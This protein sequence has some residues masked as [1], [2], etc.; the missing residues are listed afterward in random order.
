MKDCLG[1][2]GG[3]GLRRRLMDDDDEGGG[4]D[5]YPTQ[6]I[7]YAAL[8]RDSVP[9]SVP[10]ASYYNCEPGADANPYTRGCSAI[11]QCRG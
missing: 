5:G 1:D 4:G 7:S 8:M 10:G 9:C 11:T 2:D 3:F 6:Y